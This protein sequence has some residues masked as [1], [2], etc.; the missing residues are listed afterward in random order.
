MQKPFDTGEERGILFHYMSLV[1]LVPGVSA[2][3]E[4]SIDL[5]ATNFLPLTRQYTNETAFTLTPALNISSQVCGRESR[6]AG[7]YGGFCVDSCFEGGVMWCMW[8]CVV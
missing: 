6:D 8:C 2:T 3:S 7:L 5:Q 4:L 1:I